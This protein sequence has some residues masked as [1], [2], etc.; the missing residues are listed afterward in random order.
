M[1]ENDES[2]G[3]SSRFVTGKNGWD[4]AIDQI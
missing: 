3:S 2:I 4:Y 1:I